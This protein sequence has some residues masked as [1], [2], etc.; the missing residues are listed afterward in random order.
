MFESNNAITVTPV[1]T[2]V[3]QGRFIT[4]NSSS[5]GALTGAGLDAFGVSG[6]ASADGTQVAFP[7]ILLNGGKIEVEAGAAVADGVRI[8]SDATGRVITATGATAR[9]LGTAFGA[10]SGAGFALTIIG[11][12]AAGAFTA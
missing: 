2:L 4:L 9:V 5:E 10:V 1:S 11:Q 3:P 12:K 6:E 8:M 7:V